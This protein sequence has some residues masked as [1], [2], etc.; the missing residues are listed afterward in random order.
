[1][2]IIKAK[3]ARQK[4]Y[5]FFILKKNPLCF[6]SQFEKNFNVKNT[7]VKFLLACFVQ[8]LSS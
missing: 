7:V 4:N 8:S 5:N 6:L 3:N 1:M 2:F